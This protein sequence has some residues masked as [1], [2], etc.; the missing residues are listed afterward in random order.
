MN[1]SP[2]RVERGGSSNRILS[3]FWYINEQFLGPETVM[4]DKELTYEDEDGFI[5]IDKRFDDVWKNEKEIYYLPKKDDYSKYKR[6]EVV[7]SCKEHKYV[8]RLNT[9]AYNDNVL[10]KKILD[11]FNLPEIATRFEEVE[12]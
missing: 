4:W 6:G 11:R 12:N 9:K 3:I 1:R 8:V 5:H 10:R 2:L 7:F